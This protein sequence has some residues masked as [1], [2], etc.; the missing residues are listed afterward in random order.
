MQPTI[1]DIQL[2]RKEKAINLLKEYDMDGW[3]IIGSN[4]DPN[5]EYLLGITPYS[6]TVLL[7]TRDELIVLVS[8]LEESMVQF[9]HVDEVITYY[10]LKE[11][12]TKLIEILLKIKG[13]RVYLNNSSPLILLHASRI[14]SGH[15][16]IVKNIGSIL[17]ITFQPSHEYVYRL[18]A[19][20]TDEEINALKIVSKRTAEIIEHVIEE[21]IKIGMTEK[22]V[23]A[24]IYKEFYLEGSPSFEIIVAFGENSA[25][26]HHLT[27]L[28]KLRE[29][30]IG[31]IDA[32][33][34]NLSLCG[35]ITRAFFTSGYD[36][37]AR[38]VYAVVREAQ[39]ESI[40]VIKTGVSANYPDKIA[41]EV[42]DKHGYDTKLF[43]HGLGHPIG[44]EVHDVGPALSYLTPDKIKLMENMALTV[45]PA[46][47][48]KNK[49]GIRIED[50]IIVSKN[51]AIRLT[52][53]PEEPLII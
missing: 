52:K 45:E 53:A 37:E 50:N 18:R 49:W 30:E 35:D 28:K 47:Y 8:S 43:S 32:G 27:S 25:N 38:K 36:S 29:G 34:K 41:R 42:I 24:E 26:P 10:G 9:K 15:E 46:L 33:L 2:S 19:Q 11:F 23:A 44:V 7:L 5:L 40:K 3:L 16:K 1:E 21:K 51:N 31:Y 39:D 13:S 20:K 12:M 22:E 48:F 17:D 4:N 14:Y 6:N